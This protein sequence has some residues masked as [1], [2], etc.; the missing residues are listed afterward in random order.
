MAGLFED[1]DAHE[2]PA[3]RKRKRRDAVDP[4]IP[5]LLPDDDDHQDE[6]DDYDHERTQ[7]QYA[8]DYDRDTPEGDARYTYGFKWKP[9]DPT[10][11][12]F[13]VRQV[14][15]APQLHRGPH[16]LARRDPARLRAN[17]QPQLGV[18]MSDIRSYTIPLDD[19]Y[20]VE[21]HCGSCKKLIPKGST[22]YYVWIEDEH[23]FCS[24]DCCFDYYQ[25]DPDF[26]DNEPF[27]DED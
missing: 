24:W 17:L 16:P 13:T 27:N 19:P 1:D 15:P 21:R 9:G 10:P 23:D 4:E 14:A 18:R 22:M 5:E 26:L 11:E 25:D 12:G 7:W 2:R 3:N 8:Y 6:D 20:D